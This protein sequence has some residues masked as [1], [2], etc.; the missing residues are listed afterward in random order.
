M[1]K[2]PK[3]SKSEGT[4]DM[5]PGWL[6]G[7]KDIACYLGCSESTVKVFYKKFSLPIERSPNNTP[8]AYPV[9]VDQWLE[10]RQFH[11]NKPISP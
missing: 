5:K 2:K 4:T 3:S 7:W 11:E 10:K 9:K 1:T 6:Y 8:M